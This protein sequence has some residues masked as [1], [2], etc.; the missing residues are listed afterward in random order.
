MSEP[1]RIEP[2]TTPLLRIAQLERDVEQIA[3]RSAEIELL[4][5]WRV[6]DRRLIETQADAIAALHVALRDLEGRARPV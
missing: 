4:K 5:R 3:E 6:E 2:Q 1:E